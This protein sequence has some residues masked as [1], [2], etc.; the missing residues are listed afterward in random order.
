MTNAMRQRWAR[1]A[2]AAATAL[3]LFTLLAAPPALAERISHPV[4]EFTGIDKITGRI[5]SFDVY[6][7]ETVQFGALQVTPRVCYASPETEEPKTDAFVEVDEITLD[8]KIR[9]IF[10]GWMFAESPGLNAV[11]HAVYDVWLKSCKQETDVPPPEEAAAQE[12]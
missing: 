9:R 7:D 6:M 3:G 10:T 2:A 4:A 12:S 8:R 1:P 11:E 5:I